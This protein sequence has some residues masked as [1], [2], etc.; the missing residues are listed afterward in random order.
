M[1]IHKRVDIKMCISVFIVLIKKKILFLS[2]KMKTQ[3]KKN[4]RNL[5]HKQFKMPKSF[6]PL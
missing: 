6:C 3:E 4:G 2:Q 1:K 5:E